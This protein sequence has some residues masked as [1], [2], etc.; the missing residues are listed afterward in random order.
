MLTISLNTRPDIRIYQYLQGTKDNSLLLNPYKRMVVN[1]YMGGF[2]AR[3]YK[4]ENPQDIIC[5]I[6]RIEFLV[7]ISK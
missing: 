7:T 3:L 6:S 1:F 5:G 4:H 2:F